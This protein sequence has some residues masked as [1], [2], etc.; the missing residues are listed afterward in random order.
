MDETKYFAILYSMQDELIERLRA[1][2]PA[3][4]GWRSFYSSLT[5]CIVTDS[6]L[7]LLPIDDHMVHRGHA[8][9]K[10]PSYSRCFF[11]YKNTLMN[12][13]HPPESEYV[14]WLLA[15]CGF[16]RS[17]LSLRLNTRKIHLRRVPTCLTSGS[18]LADGAAMGTAVVTTDYLSVVF[19]GSPF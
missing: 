10:H 7:M 8:G 1:A 4:P 2:V 6:A 18:P 19:A 17:S 15:G 11:R 13:G 5:G 9:A 14:L 3:N 16:K 12:E